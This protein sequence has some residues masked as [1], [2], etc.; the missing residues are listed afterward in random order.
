MNGSHPNHFHCPKG[1]S[2]DSG[3]P[4]FFPN[5]TA[6]DSFEIIKNI[7]A[8]AVSALT[9]VWMLFRYIHKRDVQNS[10][11]IADTIKDATQR[12]FQVSHIEMRVKE[13]EEIQAQ[14]KKAIDELGKTLNQRLDQLFI[15]IANITNASK[16]K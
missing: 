11:L 13:I 3:T 8:S 7:L 16:E 2:D 9:I 15:A 1:V 6:M 12:A 14:N 5:D 4:F 10:K